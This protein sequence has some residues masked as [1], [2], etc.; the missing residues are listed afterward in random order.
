MIQY[1]LELLVFQLAFLLVYDLFLKKET[2]FQWN[3]AYLLVTF[4]LS[5]VLPWIKLETLKTTVTSTYAIAPQSFFQLEGVT[6]EPLTETTSFWSLLTWYE[7]VFIFGALVAV[8]IFSV[9]LVKIQGLK[10]RGRK[11]YFSGFT[12][13]IIFKSELAFSFFKN[14]F[15]G[16]GIPKEKEANILAH[17]LVHIKQW[18]SLDLLFFELMRIV[19]WFN[20]LV[21]I[22]QSR[23]SE[24]HEFIADAHVAKTNKKEQYQRLLS[25]AFQTQNI[26]FINQFFKSSL[27]KKRIVMLSKSKSKKIFQLKYLL[28]LPLVLGMLV[29]TSCEQEIKQ[30][31]V[32]SEVAS[33][34][35]DAVLIARIEKGFVDTRGTE[36]LFKRHMGIM[37][38]DKKD[39]IILNKEDFFRKA[40]FF[41]EVINMTQKEEGLSAI[42]E[43]MLANY[44]LPSSGQYQNYIKR[45]KA[46]QTIDGNLKNSIK[47]YGAN[48]LLV[49]DKDEY[50]LKTSNIL[51][52]NSL[53]ALTKEELMEFND[54]LKKATEKELVNHG[55][56]VSDDYNVIVV[57]NTIPMERIKTTQ[58]NGEEGYRVDF[59]VS[60]LE[61]TDKAIPFAVVD[62]APIF[63]G[64]ENASDKRSCF[65][66][67]M[68]NH[69]KK[70]FNYPKEAQDLGIQGRVA[71]MFTIDENGE[72][73]NI[74]KRGPHRLLEDEVE[75]I[76]KRLPKMEPGRHDGEVVEV[77]FSIP[78]NFVLSD[79]KDF[80]IQK[81]NQEDKI[82][83]H[84]ALIEKDDQT[85][86]KGKVTDVEGLNLPGVTVAKKGQE[87]G[88]ISDFKGDF[89]ILGKKGDV[90]TFIYPKLKTIEMTIE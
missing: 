21:Y 59:D 45:K 76:I 30:E 16:D 69:I 12:K 60:K 34:E 22:Y 18:H 35:S 51:E 11:E 2:F 81:E 44:S 71:V 53:K 89:M 25:E 77:P 42:A 9:K 83:V 32:E 68:Q 13:V 36:D 15:L 6:L 82:R 58:N 64:C 39:E 73:T 14:V 63:P 33:N 48:V 66:E 26:S 38:R 49:E 17:E 70:H 72:I 10:Y 27:I 31:A 43:K 46:F 86:F 47:A 20:P 7:W 90:L 19:F 55:I 88:V 62:E 5:L 75:R 4:L 80:N 67:S 79:G 65:Q 40:L 56:L 78:V 57:N 1:V 61:N 87:A 50:S 23:M 41:R 54:L 8:L 37:N 24:L 28:L 29:Y 74:K 3:R 52:V 84:G 85:F